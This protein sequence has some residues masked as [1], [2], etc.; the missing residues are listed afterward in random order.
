MVIDTNFI[1]GG[2]IRLP[3]IYFNHNPIYNMKEEFFYDEFLFG[4]F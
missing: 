4:M 3:S 1:D 2:L